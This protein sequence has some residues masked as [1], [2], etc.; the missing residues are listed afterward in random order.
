MV[1]A[2]GFKSFDPS[3]LDNYCYSQYPDVVTAIEFERMLSATG[4]YGGHLVLPSTVLQKNAD[5]QPPKKIAWLQCVGSREKNKC[6]NEYCSSVCCMYA[7]KQAIIAKDHDKSLDCTIFYMDM[8]TQGKNFDHYLESAKNKGVAFVPSKIH[9][10]EKEHSTGRL[11]LSY[12]EDSGTRINETFDLVVLSTGLEI[13]K[14]IKEL[15]ARL[16]VETDSHSFI[17]TD[18]F[19]PVSTSVPGIYAC[20]VITGPKDIPQSVMEASAAACAATEKLASARNSRITTPE[21]VPETDISRQKPRIGVFVCNCGSNIGSVIRVPDVAA[22]AKDLPGVAYVEEN[23]F[24][25]SQDTQ[26]KLAEVIREQKLNRIVIA[27]CSPTTHELLFQETLINAGLNKYLVEMANIRNH[28]S[29]VHANDPD[30][31]TKKAMTLVRMAVAKANLLEPLHQNDLPVT[32][33]ALVVGGGIAG[34]TAALSLA[35][36]GYPVTLIE[37]S[38]VMGGQARNLHR[39]AGKEEVGPFLRELTDQVTTKENISVCTGTAIKEVRGFVGNFETDIADA[40]STRTIQH[41]V[42]IIATGAN[43]YSPDE[44]LYG[45]HPAVVTHL[46]MDEL[47]R[48]NDPKVTSAQT[49]AFIQCVGSRDEN[50][51]YCSKVC[52]THTV[53]SALELKKNN[54][55][56]AVVVLYRDIRT[57]GTREILYREAREKGVMFFRYTTEKKPEVSAEGNFV[58]V[59]FDDPIIG[60]HFSVEAD[61]LCLATA[62]VP[63]EDTSLSGFFKVPRD[64]DGWLLEA[65]QKLRPVDFATEGVF[66]C[67]MAHYPKPIDESIAQAKASASRALNVLAR[68]AIQVGGMVPRIDE[69][70]CC[71]CQGCLNVCS[72]GAITFN[73]EKGVVQVNEALCKGCGACA[74]ACPSEAP[75]LKGFENKQ[76]YAQI[77]GVLESV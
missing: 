57:Y 58:N 1:L 27:A 34:M 18:S 8:R 73:P 70:L 44:Y 24:T 54:P 23:M 68:A 72:Y 75:V 25:C 15:T 28:D 69:R 46:E 43:E 12:L 35:E 7:V 76:I 56:T 21:S 74:A 4:P 32:R 5:H 31:A 48:N 49:V 10:V 59:E 6:S 39:A 14:E 50:H 20:G 62:I 26:D 41:G 42:A 19:H 17:R 11:L 9:T 30:R 66:L 33:S 52:C 47:L 51:P 64:G 16:K 13:P 2:I 37:K 71:G 36:Q 22:Y 3:V 40:S 63:L 45:K 29:W 53:L 38:E 60:C 61:I 55:D 67:G 65:H 77:E